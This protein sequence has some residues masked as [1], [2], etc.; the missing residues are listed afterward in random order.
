MPRSSWTQV[1]SSR[2]Y[3]LFQLVGY[4]SVGRRILMMPL[5]ILILLSGLLLILAGG[6]SYVAPFVYAII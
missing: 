1:L 6:L 3:T 4:F 5:L 2:L